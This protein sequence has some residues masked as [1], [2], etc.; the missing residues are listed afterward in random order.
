MGTQPRVHASVGFWMLAP[1]PPERRLIIEAALARL[2]GL[3]DRLIG[4]L[5]AKDAET[6][7]GEQMRAT[8]TYGFPAIRRL[9]T[10]LRI[11]STSGPLLRTVVLVV[12]VGAVGGLQAEP[13]TQFV[14][15][16]LQPGSP[17]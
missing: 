12:V 7:L 5:Y 3:R 14:P 16:G 2:D 9:V 13:S 11:R 10:P 4:K 8:P 15:P 1:E 6:D 17:A